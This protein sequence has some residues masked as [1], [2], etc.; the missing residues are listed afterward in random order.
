MKCEYCGKEFEPRSWNQKYCSEECQQANNNLLMQVWEAKAVPKEKTCSHCG[1]K[2]TGKP[3][4][5]YC[6]RSCKEK[7]HQ[8]RE[9]EKLKVVKVKKSCL[10]CGREYLTD[11]AEVCFC[12]TRC[13]LEY[14]G[15]VPREHSKNRSGRQLSDIVRE[16]RECNLDYGTY[17]AYLNMGKTFE[18][19]KLLAPVRNPPVHQRTSQRLRGG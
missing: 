11:D 3:S 12:S 1:G 2:F 15:L 17:R 19:L 9:Q 14:H 5:K 8:K 7:A 18:E 10:N 6:S 4:Q 16:A 13:S